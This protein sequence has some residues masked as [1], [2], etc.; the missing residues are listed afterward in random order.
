MET[1]KKNKKYI[2]WRGWGPHTRGN[3]T[4]GKVKHEPLETSSLGF[5][6]TQ[7]VITNMNLLSSFQSEGT[8]R[9]SIA[10]LLMIYT[11]TN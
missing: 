1:I 2:K 9:E 6:Y 8:D 10:L 3:V 5:P 11:D 4:M 7:T